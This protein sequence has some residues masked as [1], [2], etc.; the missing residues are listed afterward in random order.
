MFE[1]LSTRL[2]DVFGKLKKRGA[3]SADDVKAALREIR[4]ALL[5]ADVALSVVKDFIAKVE[6][7][8]AGEAITR[9][10]AP[11]QMVV[12]I[13]H[14]ALVDML[15]KEAA[16]ITLD[17]KPPVSILFV[18]LQGSGKTTTVAK[19]A[20]RLTEKE[21]KK[22]LMASL[23]VVR[24]AAQEQ[25]ATLGSQAKLAVLPT[26]PGETPVKIARR[27]IAE[28]GSQ[29]FDVVLLDTAGRLHVDE[30]MMA[31][32]KAVHDAAKPV[33]TL[34]VADAMMGQ[35]A[36]TVAEAFQERI[37]LTGIVLTRLDGDAR[38]GAALSMR[39]ATGCPIKFVG[40]GEK[41][42]A[43]DA[44][45]PERI[46]GR[47]LGMGDVV[48]LVEKAQATVDQQDIE[49]LTK[50]LEKGRFDLEDMAQQF[51][52][53]RKMGG[54]GELVSL[55]PG[56]DKMQKQVA[57]SKIDE[58]LILKQE[59]IIR[60]MTPAERRNPK[61]LHASRKQRIAT[62]SGTAVRDVNRL[63]KQFRD[64]QTMMKKM[65]KLEKMGQ[66]N[67]GLGSL[68]FDPMHPRNS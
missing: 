52:Q 53:L 46:A 68:P 39:A 19:I 45:H 2:G 1:S 13:V 61:I 5:E 7:E 25:L 11:G 60:S 67:L 32:A 28:A 38:G 21:N 51:R 18:G 16:T 10:V 15:G 44:F 65:K 30:E 22:V 35:D 41:L 24:P 49:R 31:E 14:D 27:A 63:L 58:R 26:V 50:K 47:I 40:V 4:I 48:S 33:E 64:M 42:D 57:A 43:L 20:H 6:V 9:A 55:L 56:L 66:G 3:L 37:G 34:L 12:K 36:L 54:I 23:D 29:G 59:A 17:G 62:G 8:A